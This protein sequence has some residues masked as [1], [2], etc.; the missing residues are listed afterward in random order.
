MSLARLIIALCAVLM[1][2]GCAA[3]T[4]S[5]DS[6]RSSTSDSSAAESL[7][8][9]AGS[10][11]ASSLANGDYD[12]ETKTDSSMFHPVACVL[13]VQDG[14]YTATVTMPGEGFSRWYFGTSEEA[15]SASDADIYDY[16]ADASGKYTFDIPVSALDE[17]LTVAAWGQRRD[18]WYDHTIIFYSP[19]S[20]QD[21]AA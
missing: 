6:A 14:V 7:A 20:E 15:E 2:A 9:S 12:I 17:E 3:G 18:R 10:S 5:S 16:T 19:A 13:H 8:A 21:A 11:V 1:L 4:E